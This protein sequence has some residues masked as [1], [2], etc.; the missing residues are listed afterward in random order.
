MTKKSGQCNSLPC[1]E[2]RR[3]MSG[4][5]SIFCC[6]LFPLALRGIKGIGGQRIRIG[7][8]MVLDIETNDIAAYEGRLTQSY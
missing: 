7:L 1:I 8:A 4:H 2:L 6:V 3:S 5:S